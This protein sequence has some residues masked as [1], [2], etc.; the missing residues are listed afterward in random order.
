LLGLALLPL[1][2]DFS[3]AFLVKEYGRGLRDEAGNGEV[4]LAL[5]KTISILSILKILAAKITRR[6]TRL[7]QYTNIRRARPL[8]PS[9]PYLRGDLFARYIVHLTVRTNAS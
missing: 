4:N 9:D 2:S 6:S 7:P 5:C 8:Q 3:P 1:E